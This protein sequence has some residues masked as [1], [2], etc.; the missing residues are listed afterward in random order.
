[1]DRGGCK[2]SMGVS[3]RG[4]ARERKS[5]LVISE[6][7][8]YPNDVPGRDIGRLSHLVRL[9]ILEHPGTKQIEALGG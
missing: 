9:I 8:G 2:D 1:M 3:D 7:S 5:G 4:S 6:L